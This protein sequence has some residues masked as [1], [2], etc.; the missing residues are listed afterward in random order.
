MIIE[1]IAA[2]ACGPLDRLRGHE[3]HIAGHRIIDKIVFGYA[4]AAASGYYADP[5]ITPLIVVAMVLGMSPGWGEP[6]ASIIL[7]RPMEPAMLEWWQVGPAKKNPWSAL[8]LRG[9]IWGAPA[10]PVA[11][12]TQDWSLFAYVFALAFAMPAGMKAK[13]VPMPFEKDPWGRCEWARG[14][15]AGALLFASSTI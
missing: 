9:V 7:K 14:W 4:L 8:A 2:L 11:I 3:K 13:D 1:A 5:V 15:I 6:M 12:Y 10:I